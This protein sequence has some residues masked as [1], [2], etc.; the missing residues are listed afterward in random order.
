MNISVV[1]PTDYRPPPFLFPP[2]ELLNNSIIHFADVAIV[3]V[4]DERRWSLHEASFEE[5][6]KRRIPTVFLDPHDY[7]FYEWSDVNILKQSWFQSSQFDLVHGKDG[8]KRVR[9]LY[10]QV[11]KK[12]D[13][14]I[15][16]FDKQQVVYPYVPCV[17]DTPDFIAS[18]DEFHSRKFDLIFVG[19][20]C[21]QRWDAAKALDNSELD[22]R[23]QIYD[24]T[25]DQKRPYSREN[26]RILHRQ[27]R[28]FFECGAGAQ[29][30]A[31]P[32]ELGTTALMLRQR[33]RVAWP[34]GW[35]HNKSCIEV[36]KPLVP[37]T[38]KD[39][40]EVI[41]IIRNKKLLYELYLSCHSKTLEF[42]PDKI[43][44]YVKNII[45]TEFGIE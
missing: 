21:L 20:K 19:N 15:W 16:M 33:D 2:L 9:E 17:V 36:G 41:P 7:Y 35:E 8:L 28:M 6:V 39:I 38:V 14:K 45:S 12:I 24:Q 40:K 13:F 26:W 3:I 4:E 31:R 42:I 18:Y 37:L 29:G 34:W 44:A 30:S 43:A 10:K 27:A 25:V 32:V 5:I 23:I 11:D 22:C 1:P